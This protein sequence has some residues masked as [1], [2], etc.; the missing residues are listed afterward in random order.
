VDQ[1]KAQVSMISNGV[2]YVDGVARPKPGGQF[3]G[4]GAVTNRAGK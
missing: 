2:T 3:G 1:Y 4:Q